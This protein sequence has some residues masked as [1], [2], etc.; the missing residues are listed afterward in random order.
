MRK[1]GQV[2]RRR[3]GGEEDEDWVSYIVRAT[4]EVELLSDAA[5]VADWVHERRRRK[6]RWAGHVAR[7]GDRRWTKLVLDWSP[8]GTGTRRVGRPTMRWEKSL[9]EFAG[10]HLGGNRW[11]EAAKRRAAW[12]GLEAGFVEN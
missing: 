6:W 8:I 7:M 4:H 1:M 12:R 9:E 3:I 11:T 2:V 10:R 5:G